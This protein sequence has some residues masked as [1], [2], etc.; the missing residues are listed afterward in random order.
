MIVPHRLG[1]SAIVGHHQLHSFSNW[2]EIVNILILKKNP[3]NH[4]TV[5]EAIAL[6]SPVVTSSI[7]Q[8]ALSHAQSA[9]TAAVEARIPPALFDGLKRCR[10]P[11]RLRRRYRD[12]PCGLAE[13]A[14]SRA[15]RSRSAC[16]TSLRASRCTP[17]SSFCSGDATPGRGRDGAQM[18]GRSRCALRVAACAAR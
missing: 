12:H 11:S 4:S 6:S 9:D 15:P 7:D 17:C 2:Q 10:R 1:S 8:I 16:P 18:G 14:A 5:C 13:R 3:S